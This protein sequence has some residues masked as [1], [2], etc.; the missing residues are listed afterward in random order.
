LVIFYSTFHS[1][2]ASLSLRLSPLPCDRNS[3]HLS[4]VAKCRIRFAMAS[5]TVTSS[6]L[7]PFSLPLVSTSADKPVI[8]A[9]HTGGIGSYLRDSK[10]SRQAWYLQDDTRGFQDAS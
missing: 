5:L 4:A 3:G 9:L 8:L 7:P 6:T 1:K 10:P 2:D